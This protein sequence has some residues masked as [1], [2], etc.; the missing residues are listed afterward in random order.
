M[1]SSEMAMRKR[2][3]APKISDKTMPSERGRISQLSR[4][5]KK[6]RKGAA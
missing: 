2:K 4:A 3:P 6:K 5:K 1:D